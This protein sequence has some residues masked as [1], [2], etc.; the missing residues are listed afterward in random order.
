MKHLDS[1][2]TEW[3]VVR[4]EDSGAWE[5]GMDSSAACGG[6]GAQ[7]I[8]QS[9]A[10]MREHLNQPLQVAKLAALVNVSASHYFALFKRRTGCAPIDFFIR[11]R[12][13][14]ACR[15]L[16]G[17]LLSV[18]E[19]AAALGYEDP[20]YFSRMFKSVVQVAPSEYRLLTQGTDSVQALR[21]APLTATLGADGRGRR[22]PFSACKARPAPA[23]A[24][25]SDV[26][27]L[28]PACAAV[29]A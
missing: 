19:V 3:F 1:P 29:G 6:A 14:Q 4:S 17:T 5:A 12:M 20:F 2:D 15:L 22:S 10:Y 8:D 18:K 7:K 24:Q 11:L 27:E 23:N 16:S 13:R 26:S 25:S 9:I 21:A 28:A